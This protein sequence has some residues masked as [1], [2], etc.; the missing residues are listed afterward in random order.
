MSWRQ[1]LVPE[2]SADW[3]LRRSR[4]H[5]A[6]P[7]FDPALNQDDSGE[8]ATL[9]LFMGELI[10]FGFFKRLFNIIFRD[11][12]P[13]SPCFSIYQLN[14]P[15]DPPPPPGFTQFHPRSPNLT[16]DRQRVVSS[17]P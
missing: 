1:F 7:V 5:I 2:S 13:V 4:N 3:S 12:R 16:Q 9:C 15:N 11:K 14:L 17:H 8:F 10:Q 6:S